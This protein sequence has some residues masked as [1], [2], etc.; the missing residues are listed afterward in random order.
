PLPHDLFVRM[1]KVINPAVVNI[2]TTYLPKQRQMRLDP[3][4]RNDPFYNFFEQFMG[5]M[6]PGG[7]GQGRPAE[8]LGT[9]FVIREDGLIVTNN[10]VIDKADVIKVQLAEKSEKLYDAKIIGRDPKTDVALIKIQPTGPLTVARLGSSSELQVGEWVAAFGNPYGH[11]HTMTKGIVSAIGRELDEINLAPFIQTDASINPGNS[12][13]PLVNTQ[14]L[15]IGVNTAI[16]QRAQGIGFAIP[17]DYVKAILPALEKDGGVKRGFIG[18][19][20]GEL[21]D[22]VAAYLELK[23]TDG[24]FVVQVVP[25]SPAAK[26]GFKEYDVVI[27][28]DGQKVKSWRDIQKIVARAS[29]GKEMAAKVTRNNKTVNLKLK[30]GEPPSDQVLAG[31]PA[32]K[33]D[34]QKAPFNLGFKVA[35][36]NPALAQEFGIPPLRQPG[37]IVLEVDENSVSAMAGIAPGDVIL[38]VNRVRVTKAKELLKTLTKDTNVLR[39]LKRD[40]VVLI[41]IK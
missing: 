21:N 18:L 23:S 25:G 16:D 1:N 27:E 41:R 38:D 20:M 6:G 35:D 10:H 15:V 19:Q 8:S 14:G 32:K 24:A 12:G 17:I 37:P 29:V 22:E 39:V 31:Q 40:R 7:P 33:Y 5:P 30:V 36:Y 2:S 11:G 34:G 26:A 13:G 4:F 3:R 9:G 28:L